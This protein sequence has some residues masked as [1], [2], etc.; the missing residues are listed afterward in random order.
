MILVE[1]NEYKTKNGST[2]K[3]IKSIQYSG[4]Y[5]G[6]IT[7]YE[8]LVLEGG[9]EVDFYSGKKGE[10]FWTDADGQYDAD[11]RVRKECKALEGM[12]II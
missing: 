2:V 9:I 8:F 1:G 6:I 10:H 7:L 12:D 11:I 5:S 4:G 3:Y